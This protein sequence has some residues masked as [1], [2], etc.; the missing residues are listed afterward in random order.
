[1]SKNQR[2]LFKIAKP[3]SIIFFLGCL[4]LPFFVF[5][6]EALTTE[7]VGGVIE[8][9]IKR[10]TATLN[11]IPFIVF[12]IAFIVF[13]WGVIQL[14]FKADDPE[15]QKKAKGLITWGIV[16]MAVMVSVWGI[17]SIFVKYLKLPKGESAPSRVIF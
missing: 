11:F 4:A 8:S 13:V 16:G 15:T 14:I 17:V 1:M 7:P 5:A 10:T 12:S 9:V 2:N 6:A 3:R